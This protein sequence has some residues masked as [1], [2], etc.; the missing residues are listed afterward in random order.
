MRFCTLSLV[1]VLSGLRYRPGGRPKLS[2]AVSIP[3]Q[4]QPVWPDAHEAPLPARM[5][6]RRATG[7]AA[8]KC[9]HARAP[10]NGYLD[11]DWRPNPF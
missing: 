9:R 4:Q 6:T 2:R 5:G 8:W 11:G 3:P 10:A 1:E 7:A